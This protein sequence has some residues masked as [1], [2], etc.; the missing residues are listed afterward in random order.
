MHADWAILKLEKEIKR[1]RVKP[2]EHITLD[3]SVGDTVF[4]AG[5]AKYKSSSE[6]RF[7]L[8]Y[9]EC[10]IKAIAINISL[11]DC[12]ATKGNSGGPVILKVN[13]DNYGLVGVI[14]EGNELNVSS[15]VPAKIFKPEVQKY[16]E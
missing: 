3:A 4:I 15:F 6:Q 10:K 13:E 11:T 8:S 12:R 2:L 9:S 7:D 16:I 5:Y 1:S 14:S